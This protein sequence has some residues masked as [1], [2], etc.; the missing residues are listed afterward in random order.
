[1]QTILQFLDSIKDR[2]DK[3]LQDA[4]T[5]R[6]S[7][8]IQNWREDISQAQDRGTP[9]EVRG[10]YTISGIPELFDVSEVDL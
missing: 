3:P 6:Y 5:E 1:M 2:L 4:I 10:A 7:H 9:L 8:A